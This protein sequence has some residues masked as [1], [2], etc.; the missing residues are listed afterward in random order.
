M[1]NDDINAGILFL[2]IL[3]TLLYWVPTFTISKK[4]EKLE[5]VKSNIEMETV[6]EHSNDLPPLPELYSTYTPSFLDSIFFV[7]D[8]TYITTLPEVNAKISEIVAA[9]SGLTPFLIIFSVGCYTLAVYLYVSYFHAFAFYI[10]NKIALSSFLSSNLLTVLALNF[11]II[12][13]KVVSWIIS[14]FS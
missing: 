6:M 3:V 4:L 2:V 11:I 7:E 12:T 1:N 13:F 14:I 10:I 8:F 5:I 9:G